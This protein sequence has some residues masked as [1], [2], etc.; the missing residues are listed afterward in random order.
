MV[1]VV[2]P[3]GGDTALYARMVVRVHA[4]GPRVLAELLI[5][6]A[7]ATGQPG[8]IARHLEEFARLE[9]EIVRAVGGDR[10]TPM[11]LGVVP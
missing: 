11:P 1:R 10:F 5:E 8:L 4:L 2:D 6:I 3:L 9:P 7:T